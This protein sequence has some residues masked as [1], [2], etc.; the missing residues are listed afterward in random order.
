LPSRSLD[1][2]YLVKA[3]AICIDNS[4]LSASDYGWIAFASGKPG[5]SFQTTIKE[6]SATTQLVIDRG[7]DS[8]AENRTV[9][10][11]LK[12]H[13]AEIEASF[14]GPLEWYQQ[15][16]VR[17]CRIIHEVKVGGYKDTKIKRNG[18]RYRMRLLT[19]WC[20]SRKHCDRFS[21]PFNENL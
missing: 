20:G 4:T 9:L 1:I 21:K 13:R 16:G 19:R 7:K 18:L 12:A 5:V 2:C 14:G 8:D 11:Q 10:D 15:E 3:E 17:V 6:H